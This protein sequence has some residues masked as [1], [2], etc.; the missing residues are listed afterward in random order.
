MKK[1]HAEEQDLLE[2]ERGEMV[3]ERDVAVKE[4][5]IIEEK[6]A[7]LKKAKEEAELKIDSLEKER[8]TWRESSREGGC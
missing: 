4:K 8:E 2:E 3:H 1:E 7:L 6:F 5:K